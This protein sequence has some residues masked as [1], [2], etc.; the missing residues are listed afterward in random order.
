MTVSK[1]KEA[2]SIVVEKETKS[3]STSE[4]EADSSDVLSSDSTE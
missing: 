1:L 2:D 4:T 3:N